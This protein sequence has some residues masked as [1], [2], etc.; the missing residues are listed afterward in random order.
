MN[1]DEQRVHYAS[2]ALTGLIMSANGNPAYQAGT[3]CREAHR[4]AS[5]MILQGEMA[6][7]EMLRAHDEVSSGADA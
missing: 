5:M 4:F 3:L 2:A 1:T 7:R 6:K